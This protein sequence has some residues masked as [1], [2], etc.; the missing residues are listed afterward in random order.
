MQHYLVETLARST[1]KLK[2]WC[3]IYFHYQTQLHLPNVQQNFA[4][5]CNDLQVIDFTKIKKQ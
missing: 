4:E 2:F 1:T 3:N 5:N